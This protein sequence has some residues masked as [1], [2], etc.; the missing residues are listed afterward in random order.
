MYVQKMLVSFHVKPVEV[1]T[2]KH[3]MQDVSMQLKIFKKWCAL[4]FYRF[5]L[6][7]EIDVRVQQ[8]VSVTLTVHIPKYLEE[9]GKQ[10]RA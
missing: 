8:A 7:I 5:F 10:C 3:D 2:M 4:H 6:G 1:I 9:K